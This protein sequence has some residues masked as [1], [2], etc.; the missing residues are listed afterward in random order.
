MKYYTLCDVSEGQL[1]STS[2]GLYI[3]A[4]NGLAAESF[5]NGLIDDV[6]IYEKAVAP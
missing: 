2:N 5:W 6:R 4:G 1:S 3:G